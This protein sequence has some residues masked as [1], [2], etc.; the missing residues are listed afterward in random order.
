M[1]TTAEVTDEELRQA[2]F[3]AAA[4]NYPRSEEGFRWICKFNGVPPEIAPRAWR[5]ASN[6]YMWE[7]AERKAVEDREHFAEHD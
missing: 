6:Q 5:Y 7:Y 2:G 4:R 3:T 1:K